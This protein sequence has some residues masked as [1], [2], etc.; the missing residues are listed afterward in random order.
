[1]GVKDGIAYFNVEPHNSRVQIL[2]E[3]PSSY[4]YYVNIQGVRI[5]APK[6]GEAC[7]K[8]IG[9]KATKVIL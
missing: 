5:A 6:P 7:I 4:P 3:M 8:I 2:Y 1:M 9:T